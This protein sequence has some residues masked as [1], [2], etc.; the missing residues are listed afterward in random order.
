MLNSTFC[1]VP[2]SARAIA[3]TSSGVMCRRSA[4][5]W[6]VMPGAP[7]AMQ[8]STASIR[9]GSRPPRE[10]RSVATLLTFTERRVI[11]IRRSTFG[12]R[13]GRS[14]RTTNHEPRTSST[15]VFLHHVH[16]LLRPAANLVLLLPFQHHSQKRL[17]TGV[18]DEE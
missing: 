17:G 4:R 15:E 18:T 5:G 7:A 13:G 2:C 9:F 11:D 16:D 12:V 10:L 14:E 3:R 1:G 6:T 8:T